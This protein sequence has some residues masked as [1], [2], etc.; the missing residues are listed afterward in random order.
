MGI[1]YKVNK[2]NEEKPLTDC[3]PRYYSLSQ[4]SQTHFPVIVFLGKLPSQPVKSFQGNSIIH[5]ILRDWAYVAC[6]CFH[7]R[8]REPVS[9]HF[10]FTKSHK[11]K[12]KT[13]QKVS[14]HGTRISRDPLSKLSGS[15]IDRKIRENNVI[16]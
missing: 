9:L 16:G 8:N 11:S 4:L 2:L 15:S 7:F 1:Q 10:S 12:Q 3:F 5:L 13:T 14:I 6:G